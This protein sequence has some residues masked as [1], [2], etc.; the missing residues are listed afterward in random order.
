MLNWRGFIRTF[1]Y[2]AVGFAGILYLFI[3]LVDPYDSVP[4]SLPLE[5]EPISTNQRFAYPSLARN[6]S[7]DSAIIGTSTARLLKPSR[8][9]KLTG[10][11]WVNL[12]MNSATAY[13]QMEML[14]LFLRHHSKVKQVVI[15]IDDAWCNP[16]KEI[17]KFTFRPF[18]PWMYD[19]DWWND[20]LYLFNDKALE[21]SVRL[22]EYWIARREAKYDRTGYRDFTEDFGD[23]DVSNARNKLYPNPKRNPRR[24]I[25][26]NLAPIYEASRNY[27]SHSFLADRKPLLQQ[28][29]G[30]FTVVFM[31]LHAEYLANGSEN[32]RRC[33]GSMINAVSDIDNIVVIDAMQINSMT[34]NDSNYWDPLHFNTKVATQIEALISRSEVD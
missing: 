15:G 17:Q 8:L 31:P 13:E 11:N 1:C 2:A 10:D 23:Y 29:E 12:A 25:G 14:T 27:S 16:S 5:R 21:N 19:D 9:N 30:L 26:R 20:L 3:L 34:L 32:Y 4:F 22:I 24:S 28:Y 6:P 33:K 7:F 18:P